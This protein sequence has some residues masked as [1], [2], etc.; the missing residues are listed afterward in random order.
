MIEA[1]GDI[2]R[3]QHKF[4]AIVIT[5]NGFVKKNG[6][7]VMGRGIALIAARK[8]PE[9]PTRLGGILSEYGNIVWP[10]EF[11]RWN[12][13][14]DYQELIFSFPVKPQFGRNGEPGWRVKANIGLIKE[15]ASQLQA[16]AN[17]IGLKK[18]LMPRPGCGNGGLKW[19]F[20]KPHL[21]AIL[22]DRFTVMEYEPE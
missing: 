6:E 17:T 3:N 21:E 19:E 4:D 10:F 15:S 20:V 11:N 2:W 13:E 22:D 9:F 12:G 14:A 8:Y 16:Y 7:A 18:V 5:T 1:Y